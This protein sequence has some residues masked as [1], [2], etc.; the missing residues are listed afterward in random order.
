MY[1]KLGRYIWRK[2]AIKR[3]VNIII[4][5]LWLSSVAQ[6]D[7]HNIKFI[8]AEIQNRKSG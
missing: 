1:E 8:H 2:N 4:V 6:I 5:L 3:L 7:Q